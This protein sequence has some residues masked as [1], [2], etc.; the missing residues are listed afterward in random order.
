MHLLCLY[1]RIFFYLLN[2]LSFWDYKELSSI[3]WTFFLADTTMYFLL[4]TEPSFLLILQCTFS[5]YWAFFLSGTSM[6]FL[7]FTTPSF[8]LRLRC[9]LFHLQNLL[10]FWDS[11][12]PSSI[13]YTLFL[14]LMYFLLS[15]EPSVF[16]RLQCTFFWV[17]ADLSFFYK[18]TYNEVFCAMYLCLASVYFPKLQ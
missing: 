18:L 3:Y 1:D 17:D 4:S 15:A 2:L 6:Y 12:V 5:I 10:S 7:L 11:N 8:F 16:L 13:Y 14:S 9:T